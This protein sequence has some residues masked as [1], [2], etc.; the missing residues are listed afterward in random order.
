MYLFH[1]VQLLLLLLCLTSGWRLTAPFY[2]HKQADAIEEYLCVSS[3]VGK[4][5]RRGAIAESQQQRT[6]GAVPSNL[7]QQAAGEESCSSKDAMMVIADDEPAQQCTGKSDALV[8]MRLM[9]WRLIYVVHLLR[10]AFQSYFLNQAQQ[11]KEHV[12]F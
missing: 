1:V 9:T 7:D 8:I 11:K 2:R 5:A 12:W 10:I 3:E 6:S 4:L